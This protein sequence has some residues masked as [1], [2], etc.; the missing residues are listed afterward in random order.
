MTLTLL[1][2]PFFVAAYSLSPQTMA[3][4]RASGTLPYFTHTEPYYTM[5]LPGRTMNGWLDVWMDGWTIH[6]PTPSLSLSLF[7]SPLCVNGWMD[8][9]MDAAQRR[10]FIFP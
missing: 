2:V 8:A 5:S 7:L 3:W 10:L 4:M 9:N 1:G 6:A